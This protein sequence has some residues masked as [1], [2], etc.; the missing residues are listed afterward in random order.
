MFNSKFGFITLNFRSYVDSDHGLYN[1]DNFFLHFDQNW[2]S[3]M[4]TPRLKISR[5]FEGRFFE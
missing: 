4:R 2:F 5:V 1:D 3:A